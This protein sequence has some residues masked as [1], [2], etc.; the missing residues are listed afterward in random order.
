MKVYLISDNIDTLTGM[1]LAGVLGTVVHDRDALEQ[2]LNQ[3]RNDMDVGIV[4]VTEKIS[5][6]APD[7]IDSIKKAHELPLLVII[8]DRH[9]SVRGEDSITA[10]VK[11]TIGI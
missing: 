7:L 5:D 1:R 8:P 4:L 3:V 9:G 11:E 2:C 10:Y 6:M